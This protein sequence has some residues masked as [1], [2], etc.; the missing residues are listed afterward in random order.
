[1]SGKNVAAFC[2]VLSYC[3]VLASTASAGMG[4]CSHSLFSFCSR[5]WAAAVSVA[6]VDRCWDVVYQYNLQYSYV[7]R[8]T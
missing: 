7:S 6:A 1:M 8:T 3:S 2:N 5:L 4:L